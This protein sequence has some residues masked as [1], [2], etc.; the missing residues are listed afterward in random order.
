MQSSNTDKTIVHTTS[1]IHPGAHLDVGVTVGPFCV[2]GENVV[3]G[4][5]TILHSHVVLSGHTTLGT[6]NEIFPFASVGHAPQDLKYKGEPTTLVIGNQNKIRE[7]VTLQ[8]GTVQDRGTTSIGN[9]NLFMAYTHVAHDCVVGN[10][11]IL[12]NGAQ[13]SGHVTLG[14]G[15]VIGGLSGIH[16]FCRMGDFAMAAGGAKIVEDVPP[17][18]LAQ[19]DRAVLRGLNSIGLRRKGFNATQLK[20][21]KDCYRILFLSQHATLES[22]LE[23]CYAETWSQ[24]PAIAFFLEFFKNS[25]RGIMRPPAGSNHEMA[26]NISL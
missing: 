12:A 25:K 23:R 26:P 18:C 21:I 7:S 2:V 6:E 16:Q 9:G 17:Y 24:D 19:G 11:N 14:N 8:P 20:S 1:L 3:V 10:D 4:K 13:L 15:T 5:G 22:A